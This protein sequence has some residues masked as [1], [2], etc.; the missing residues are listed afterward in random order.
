[1]LIYNKII[2]AFE[3]ALGP[4]YIIEYNNN[5]AF[6]W[7]D[8]LPEELTETC[9]GI[10]RQDSG[11]DRYIGDQ[12]IKIDSMHISFA[13]ANT[14]EAFENFIGKIEYIRESLNNQIITLDENSTQFCKILTG[15]R[16]DGALERVNG[17]DWIL[18]DFYFQVQTYSSIYTSNNRI[19]AFKVTTSGETNYVPLKGILNTIYDC[20]KQF[21]S[22][23]SGYNNPKA[24]NTLNNYQQQFIVELVPSSDDSMLSTL[25]TNHTSD[26]NYLLKYSDGLMTLTDVEVKLA[27]VNEKCIT[28]DI[29][30][31]Q[32]TFI[33]K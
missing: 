7:A 25:L 24:N 28:G 19:F 20:N 31:L 21:D 17:K 5:E 29:F 8:V 27:H 13:I 12:T 16:S 6:N 22:Y 9:Y 18:T 1:M 30:T 11:E 15:Y 14:K 2:E 23:V 33:N 4:E 3:E 32:L 26:T 10:L